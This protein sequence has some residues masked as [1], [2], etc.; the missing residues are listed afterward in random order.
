MW[1]KRAADFFLAWRG[2]EDDRL[3]RRRGEEKPVSSGT[4]T[5]RRDGEKKHEEEGLE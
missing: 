1:G 3:G 5:L 4:E 2:E